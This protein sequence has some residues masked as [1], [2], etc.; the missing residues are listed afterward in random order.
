[1]NLKRVTNAKLIGVLR[2]KKHVRYLICAKFVNRIGSALYNLALLTLAAKQTYSTLAISLVKLGENL[3]GLLDPVLAYMTDRETKR[4]KKAALLN[5]VQILLYFMLAFLLLKYQMPLALFVFILLANVLSDLLDSYMGK[6]FTPFSKTWIDQSERREISSLDIVLFSLSIIIGQLVGAQWLVIYP[7]NFWGLALLNAVTFA[8]SL[9]FLKKI[10]FDDTVKTVISA[11]N[12]FSVTDFLQKMRLAYSHM[13]QKHVLQTMWLLTVVKVIAMGYGLLLNVAMVSTSN[14]RIGSYSQTLVVLQLTS[15]I[16]LI[17]GSFLRF[18]W[19]EKLSY[20]QLIMLANG[21]L[22]FAIGS[23]FLGLPLGYTLF[24]KLIGVIL[25]GYMTPKYYTDLLQ[26][27]DEEQLTR[28]DSLINFVLLISSPLGILL[29]TIC[30]QLFS[31]KTSWL[32]ELGAAL[33]FI[34][35]GE[36][37]IYR[38]KRRYG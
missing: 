23:C 24:F 15:F 14:L 17:L 34:I 5:I 10:K 7:N 26:V 32:L 2:K 28:V 30:L 37:V 31:L 9:F 36:I 21:A 35:V 29:T 22:V 3:P 4:L 20:G 11:K 6:M 12:H 1:M 38:N 27:I 13:Q 19:L 8:L 25:S 16:G 18:N 33:L